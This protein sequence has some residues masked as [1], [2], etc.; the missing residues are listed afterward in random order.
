MLVRRPV[1]EQVGSLDAR[2]FYY[3]EETEWCLRARERGW[4]I[5][6]VPQARLWHKGV[7]RDYHPTP[8]VT[9]YATRNRLLMMSK[10]RAP[11]TAWMLVWGQM[12]RTLVSWT[13]KPKWRSMRDHRDVM[14]R[15]MLDFLRR[16]WGRMSA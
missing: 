6:H 11:L 7:Q 13:I 8:S 5:V 16:R 15:G 14:W 2:F 12:L 3:W 10:H 1:I 9:Y 4:R